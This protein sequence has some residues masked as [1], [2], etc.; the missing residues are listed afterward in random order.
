MPHRT[1]LVTSRTSMPLSELLIPFMKLSNNGHAEILIKE[2]GKVK[3]G[4]RLGKGLGR[5]EIGTQIVRAES[6]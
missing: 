5:D 6:G 4:R 1:Q 2:M 3:K